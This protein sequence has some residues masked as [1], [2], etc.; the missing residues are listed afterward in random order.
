MRKAGARPVALMC[1]ICGREFGTHS[2]EIHLKTCKK[3]WDIEQDKLPP[4][5]RRQCPQEPTGFE[6]T[7]KV[8]KS[9]KVTGNN[10]NEVMLAMNEVAYSKWD[11]EA[12]VACKNCNRTFLP[13]RLTI[14]SRSCRPSDKKVMFAVNPVSGEL[15]KMSA[16]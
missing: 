7:M 3:K 14:H 4:K 8:V 13:D 6:Q 1:Y 16:K 15:K 2:L 10:R 11:N 5:Q 12:L 9:K